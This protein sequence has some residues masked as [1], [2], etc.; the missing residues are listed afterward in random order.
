MSEEDIILYNKTNWC[1]YACRKFHIKT[2]ELGWP[3]YDYQ[4]YQR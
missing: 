2:I 1:H 4:R 3:I